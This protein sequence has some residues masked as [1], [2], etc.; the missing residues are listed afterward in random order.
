VYTTELTEVAGRT[1]V[2]PLPECGWGVHFR[3]VALFRRSGRF[4][5]AIM[6]NLRRGRFGHDTVIPYQFQ[7]GGGLSAKLDLT[8]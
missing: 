8:S 6:S 7:V 4:F 2:V 5:G 1:A 3:V